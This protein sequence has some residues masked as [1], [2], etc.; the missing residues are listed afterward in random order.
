[1][2][3]AANKKYFSTEKGK[4][5]NAR[6]RNSEKAKETL[7]AWRAKNKEEKRYYCEKCDVA[8]ETSSSN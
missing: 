5:A 6:Y 4:L 1:M 3:N 7:A 8:F 2:V